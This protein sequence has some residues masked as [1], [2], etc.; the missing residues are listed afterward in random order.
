MNRRFLLFLC[1]VFFSCASQNPIAKKIDYSDTASVLY[2]TE[3]TENLLTE[4]KILEALSK[5]KNLMKNAKG[6]FQVEAVYK[7]SLNKAQEEFA[8]FV[9]NADW[10]KAL[11]YFRSLR[12]A[13][14][15]PKT[16][17][18]DE[19]KKHQAAAWLK[20]GWRVLSDLNKSGKSVSE[21]NTPSSKAVAEMIKGTVTVIADKGM[22]IERG[23]GYADRMMGSGFF[24]DE[25][26]HFI[27]NYHVIQSEVDPKYEGY[28]RLYIK[29]LDDP[30]SKLPVKAVGWDPI[31]DL[32]LVKAEVEPQAIFK[33]GSSKSLNIGDKIYAIGSPAG[34]EKTLTSGIVSAKNRRL[35]SLGDVLQ[36][37]API[38]RGNS[39]GPVIDESGFVQAVAFAGLEQNEGL[40]F[41]VP[42]ELLKAVL[43]ALYK[44]GEVEHCWLGLYGTEISSVTDFSGEGISA[45]YVMPG[46]PAYKA[47]IPDGAVISEID[48]V[49]V[50]KIDDVKKYLLYAGTGSI[51]R[52]AGFVKNDEDKY[53]KKEWFV[54]LEKRPE[55]PGGLIFKNDI[56]S[57][58]VLPFYGFKLEYAGSKKTFRIKSVEPG[59]Y[60]DEAGFSQNDFIEIRNVTYNEKTGV[61]YTLFYAKKLKSGYIESFIGAWAYADNPSYL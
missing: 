33:L 28:S 23:V 41:A 7:K 32:A 60:A 31:L 3:R 45:S 56:P 51:L 36:I 58:A 1:G 52:V 15:T 14:N 54:F 17:T 49:P 59:S 8:A 42:V 5:A 43:P 6:L 2:E 19:I 44:G 55:M 30:N 26:G 10:E 61:I 47:G 12:A 24:I 57:R 22:K 16:I 11:I 13:E 29:S 25:K 34:L 21:H 20:N 18:E 48:T 27:T 35:L 53:E 46:S 9:K 50:K 4:G 38:N 40:N 37:D 39:G